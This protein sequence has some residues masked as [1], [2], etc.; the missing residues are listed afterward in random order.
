MNDE[1]IKIEIRN[2]DYE[3]ELRAS[4]KST[5]LNNLDLE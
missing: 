2:C 1:S 4:A 3:I 5:R